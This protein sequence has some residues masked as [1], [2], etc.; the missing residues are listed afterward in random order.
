MM[1]KLLIASFL[2]ITG[3]TWVSSKVYGFPPEALRDSPPVGTLETSLKVG[4]AAPSFNLS[5]GKN[6]YKSQDLLKGNGTVLVFY[7]GYW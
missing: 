4:D 6:N 5:N 1:K 2:F 7:R 3:C